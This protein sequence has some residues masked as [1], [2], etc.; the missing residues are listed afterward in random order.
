[1]RC[2]AGLLLL[3]ALVSTNLATDDDADV[4]P[5][6][7]RITRALGEL[8]QEGHSFGTLQRDTSALSA[9]S[10][11]AL[12]AIPDRERWDVD[13]SGGSHVY[14]EIS[15]SA[16]DALLRTLNVTAGDVVYDLGSGFGRFVTQGAEVRPLSSHAHRRGRRC[17]SSCGTGS[18]C[19]H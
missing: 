7:A 6:M 4:P 1:M 3:L 19:S 17:P 5:S 15:P 9:S 13:A 10:R 14:G 8:Y 11:R 16:V 18:H 12:G 2:R